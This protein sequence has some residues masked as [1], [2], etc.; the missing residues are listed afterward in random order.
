MDQL[1]GKN[2]YIKYTQKTVIP[3][4]NVDSFM[5]SGQQNSLSTVVF[6]GKLTWDV[7]LNQSNELIQILHAQWS[8]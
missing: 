6:E 3:V 5:E 1:I 2:I 7:K 8:N 4:Q